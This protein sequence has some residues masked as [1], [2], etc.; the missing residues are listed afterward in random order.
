MK[1]NKLIP[2]LRVSSL[3]KSL[4]FYKDILGFKVE[5]E[6]KEKKFAFISNEGA[7]MMLEENPN[8]KWKTGKLEHPYGRGVNFQIA[9]KDLKVL[10]GKLKENNYSLK[11]E[12]TENWYRQEDNLLG[13][14]ELLILDPD[15][16]LLRFSQGIGKRKA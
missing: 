16:Y 12:P 7:Q 5:Y 3:Q 13:V 11:T 8:S 4:H 1:F 10:L 9:V 2:E 14:R 6:R 15:G